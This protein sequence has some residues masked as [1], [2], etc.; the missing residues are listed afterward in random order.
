LRYESSELHSK[1]ETFENQIQ[2]LREEH[3]ISRND[4]IQMYEK[5]VKDLTET[6]E[7]R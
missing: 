7:K 1:V 5:Q 2:R 6:Y 4:L 3:D